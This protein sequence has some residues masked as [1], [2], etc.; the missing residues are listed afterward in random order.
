M[1]HRA[2]TPGHYGVCVDTDFEYVVSKNNLSKIIQKVTIN[3]TGDVFFTL[4]KQRCSFG[5]GTKGTG[6]GPSESVL[7]D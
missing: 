1:K 3:G 7:K 5:N 4:S 6:C 2:T